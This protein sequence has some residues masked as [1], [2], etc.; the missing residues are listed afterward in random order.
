[1]LSFLNL[2]VLERMEGDKRDLTDMYLQQAQSIRSLE[3]RVAE[4]HEEVGGG[5]GAFN[6]CRDAPLHALTTDSAG[7]SSSAP[8]P[9]SSSGSSLHGCRGSWIGIRA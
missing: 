1:M 3:N 6:D 9:S 8:Q 5:R 7:P 4:M 2:Q